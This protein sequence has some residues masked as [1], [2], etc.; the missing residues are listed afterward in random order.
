MPDAEMG[1]HHELVRV[2]NKVRATREGYP[3]LVGIVEKIEDRPFGLDYLV[4]AI[5]VRDN[6]T[7]YTRD[8]LSR[9]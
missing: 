9:V 3:A 6:G 8:E 2:G 1:R 5:H 7:W 4:R